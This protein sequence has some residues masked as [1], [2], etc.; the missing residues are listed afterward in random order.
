M[1]S[2]K[3]KEKLGVLSTINT[4]GII[5]PKKILIAGIGP[6]KKLST[7]VLRNVSGKIAQKLGVWVYQSFQS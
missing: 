4:L 6:K 1:Q 2:M 3:L 7:D 5:S